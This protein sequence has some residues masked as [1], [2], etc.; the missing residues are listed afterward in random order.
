MF[1]GSWIPASVWTLL[2]VQV[3]KM[4]YLLPLK[5]NNHWPLLFSIA[6]ILTQKVHLAAIL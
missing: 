1:Q 5:I 2:A 3:D 6:A 4:Y